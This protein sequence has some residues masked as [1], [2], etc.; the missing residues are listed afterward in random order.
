MTKA[1]LTPKV[2][3]FLE[4]QRE[5]S[6]Q[7]EVYGCASAHDVSALEAFADTMTE[8]ELDDACEIWAAEIF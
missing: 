4:L 5:I 6:L 8:E 3:K 1:F 2:E 7:I